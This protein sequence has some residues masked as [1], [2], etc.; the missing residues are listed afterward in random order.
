MAKRQI[1]DYVFSPGIAGVGTLKILDKVDVD[2][3]LLIT[4]ATKNVF[5]YN[6][7]DPSLPISVDFTSTTDG[8]DPDF[9]YSNTLSNGVTTITF[10]YD[11]SSHF[12]SDKILIFVETE[13]QK[14]RPYDFGTDAIER[15]RFAEPQSMLD[16]DFE[17][18]IQPT[19]WQSLDLLRGYPSI[20][21]VPGS[22]IALVAVTTDASLG[23]GA[24]G[25]SKIT[26]DTVLD[27][28]LVVGDPVSIKGLDDSVIGFA[29][30]EGSFIIDSVPS[31][32]QFTYYAKAKVGVT[33][34]T[35]LLSSFTVLKQA[36]FYTGAAIG[37]SPTFTV[38]TQG[39][40]GNFA[41]RGSAAS[42]AT[43]L[44]V[45]GASTLPPIGAPLGGTGIAT[46]TQVTAVVDTDTT[47]NITDS[48][49][50]P[51]SEITFNDTADIEIGSGLDNGNGETIFVTNIQGNV[52]T[53]SSPYQQNK[54]GNSFVSQAI[55][56]A[57]SNF[58]NGNSASFDI[59][60]ANGAYTNVVVNPQNFYNN[61][62]TG[63]YTGLG[64]WC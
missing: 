3:I 32:T 29:K 55:A 63:A 60:R 34:A 64:T 25:P 6:F 59:T 18:G 19:K 37:T 20:Y 22:D 43:R 26:V 1:R 28:G 4:N 58:G 35:P 39:A 13:E 42:G 61:V 38:V 56:A 33:P 36:G 45:S 48:F 24:I 17:Y 44:G 62:N 11:T 14:T 30:A 23:S 2:Q 46:G 5:L 10:L 7:S 52:V 53:L 40:S 51:V 49:T 41:T 31:T 16:A 8:S 47:L 27:H 50:A 57:G 9:P 12:P 15:M 54:T 21:E